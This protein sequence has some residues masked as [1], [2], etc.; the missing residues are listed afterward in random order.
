MIDFPQLECLHVGLFA[1][2]TCCQRGSTAA[3]VTAEDA[4]GVLRKAVADKTQTAEQFLQ[5]FTFAARPDAASMRVRQ[6]EHMIADNSG[7]CFYCHTGKKPQDKA[8]EW[9]VIPPRIPSRW[10][11]HS[12]FQHEPHRMFDCNACHK[13]NPGDTGGVETSHAT[14]DVLMPSISVCIKCHTSKSAAVL[15]LSGG[16]RTP[17][18]SNCVECHTYHKH[19]VQSHHERYLPRSERSEGRDGRSVKTRSISAFLEGK[20]E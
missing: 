14:G 8:D 13:P 16:L 4:P 6:F 5:N 15:K 11:P 20:S 7:G 1:L 3:T 19:D 9:S 17:A 18:R 2:E 12:N 10:L